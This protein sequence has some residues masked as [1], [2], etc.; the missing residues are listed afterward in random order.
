MISGGFKVLFELKA[1]LASALDS[2][3]WEK[4]SKWLPTPYGPAVC[5]WKPSSGFS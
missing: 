2:M 3:S 5:L 4:A 1:R